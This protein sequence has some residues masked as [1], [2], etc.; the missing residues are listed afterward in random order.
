M[1]AVAVAE[2]AA[3]VAQIATKTAAGAGVAHVLAYL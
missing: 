3:R 2:S 1:A